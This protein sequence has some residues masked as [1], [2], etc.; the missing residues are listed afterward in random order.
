MVSSTSACEWVAIYRAGNLTD[1]YSVEKYSTGGYIVA[2]RTYDVDWVMRTTKGSDIDWQWGTTEVSAFLAVTPVGDEQGIAVGQMVTDGQRDFIVVKLGPSGIIWQYRYG[3]SDNDEAKAVAGTHDG[4]YV[5]AAK[6]RSFGAQVD[7]LWILRLDV[8]GNIVWQKRYESAMKYLE[9]RRVY[10]SEDAGYIVAGNY[11]TP[12]TD[13]GGGWFI[14]LDSNGNILLQKEYRHQENVRGLDLYSIRE[15]QDDGYIQVMGT[16]ENY[17]EETVFDVI[18]VN[19]LNTVGNIQW[20]NKYISPPYSLTPA[21]I[22]VLDNGGYLLAGSIYHRTIPR[23]D[24]KIWLTQLDS[25]GEIQWQQRYD[26]Y[27]NEG[28]SFVHSLV[29]SV[30]RILFVPHEKIIIGGFTSN[31]VSDSSTFLLKVD[32]KGEL[33]DKCGLLDPPTAERV[34]PGFTVVEAEASFANPV[35]TNVSPVHSN[36]ALQRAELTRRVCSVWKDEITEVGTP[37]SGEFSEE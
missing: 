14:K 27:D 20:S 33:P 24:A 32:A 6:T 12:Y 5:V 23:Q 10:E 31:S 15:T 1:S 29:L 17:S 37:A 4:G 8:N 11:M 35:N 26:P 22:R 19:K 13:V 30:D 21:E 18:I 16:N 3:G 9:I 2:G 25:S 7:N 28:N 36:I 34:E